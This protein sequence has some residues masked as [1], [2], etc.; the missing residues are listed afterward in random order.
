MRRTAVVC[1][2]FAATLGITGTANASIAAASPKARTGSHIQ[3]VVH[4]VTHTVGPGGKAPATPAAVKGQ[5]GAARNGA[6]AAG[7]KS[8]AAPE[9]DAAASTGKARAGAP[10]AT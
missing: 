4:T 9:K 3:T 6:P 7:E 5:A 2:L 10:Q 1:M 8:K